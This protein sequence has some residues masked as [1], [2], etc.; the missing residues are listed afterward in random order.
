MGETKCVVERVNQQEKPA[1]IALSMMA[2]ENLIMTVATETKCVVERVN[3][4]EK[5]ALIALSMMAEENSRTLHAHRQNALKVKGGNVDVAREWAE[6]VERNGTPDLLQ[7][8]T[9]KVCATRRKAV[10]KPRSKNFGTVKT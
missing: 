9:P 4:Q 6:I 8:N 5:P 3:Q 2:E 7:T 10:T 1:L